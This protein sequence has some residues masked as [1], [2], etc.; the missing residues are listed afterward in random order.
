MSGQ[1]IINSQALEPDN[2]QAP[3][4]E[5]D[6]SQ[7]PESEP[8]N[9]QAP[10]SEPDN[11]APMTPHPPSL[12]SEDQHI[13]SRLPIT[14]MQ[15]MKIWNEIFPDAMAKLSSET[16]EPKGLSEAGYTIRDKTDWEGVYSVLDAARNRYQEE[17]RFKLLRKSRRKF[18]D[19][20]DDVAAAS[21]TV[22]KFAPVLRV[23]EVVFDAL[24]TA[25]NV[26]KEVL[27][28]VGVGDL[29]YIFSKAETFMNIFPEDISVR[30]AS[31]DLTATIIDAIEHAIGF[32]ISN[33]YKAF[34]ALL[35]PSHYQSAL[36]QSLTRIKTKSMILDEQ[37]TESNMHRQLIGTRRTFANGAQLENVMSE[38]ESINDL[39]G[40]RWEEYLT[41]ALDTSLASLREHNANLLG[42]IA[43]LKHQAK[44]QA[45]VDGLRIE[46]HSLKIE[47]NS[48]K[49][50]NN[51][52][53]IENEKL[54]AENEKLRAEIDKLRAENEKL[55]A[56][57]PGREREAPGRERE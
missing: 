6:N 37:A 10:E 34:K 27:E 47:I 11:S 31:I 13:P 33:G 32:F 55:R 57:A 29:S 52:L 7:A 54:R 15:D 46:I 48:L 9:S 51:S 4:S 20:V 25:A 50:E 24:K 35:I 30:E 17:G 44:L 26:R 28:S 21:K 56:Q 41:R 1:D 43:S 23:V 3:E 38:V 42:E 22:T 36:L 18:A 12:P 19:K 53:K 2:S 49:I 8:D 16:N 5:P 39:V 14:D 40:T 45:E